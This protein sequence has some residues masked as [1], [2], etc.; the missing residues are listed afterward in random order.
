MTGRQRH[1]WQYLIKDIEN[2]AKQED[3]KMIL[4][5]IKTWLAKS[6]K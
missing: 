6:F 5:L 4:E 2:F 3:C 1:K